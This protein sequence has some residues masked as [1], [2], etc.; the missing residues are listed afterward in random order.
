[1]REPYEGILMSNQYLCDG[2]IELSFVTITLSQ[3]L[4]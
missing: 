1:M 4:K 2:V 3:G